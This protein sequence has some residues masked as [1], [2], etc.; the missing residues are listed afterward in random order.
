MNAERLEQGMAGQGIGAAMLRPP[1]VARANTARK[2]RLH[3]ASLWQR[4]TTAPP[5]QPAAHGRSAVNC[6][7]EVVA[8][9]QQGK[10]YMFV[11]EADPAKG[12]APVAELQTELQNATHRT[13]LFDEDH[14]IITWHRI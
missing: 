14:R 8:T 6:L 5:R 3:F 11:H 12:G 1:G 2:A 13:Q 4:A 7:R 10:K 9:L